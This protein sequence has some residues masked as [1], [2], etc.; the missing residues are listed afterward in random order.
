MTLASAPGRV[1]SFW[2]LAW[3]DETVIANY[4]PVLEGA[5]RTLEVETLE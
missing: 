4:E 1:W 3:G 2:L 5:I